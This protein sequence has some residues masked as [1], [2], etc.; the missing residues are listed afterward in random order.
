MSDGFVLDLPVYTPRELAQIYSKYVKPVSYA[1]VLQWEKAG[2]ISGGKDGFTAKKTPRGR[3]LIDAAEV[4]R[5]LLQAG[6]VKA[7]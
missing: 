3:Y 4:E 2:R 6:A 7:A 5:L 1:T